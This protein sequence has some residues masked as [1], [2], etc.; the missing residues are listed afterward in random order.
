[1]NEVSLFMKR[2]LDVSTRCYMT[3]LLYSPVLCFLGVSVMSCGDENVNLRDS[4][5]VSRWEA[6]GLASLFINIHR[7]S[8]SYATQQNVP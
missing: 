5:S 6:R 8:F 3:Y 7:S 2:R 1:M 4:R